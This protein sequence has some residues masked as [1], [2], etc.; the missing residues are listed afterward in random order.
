VAQEVP[1]TYARKSPFLP[2]RIVST[3]ARIEGPDPRTKVGGV[4]YS[5]GYEALCFRAP[6]SACVDRALRS[7]CVRYPQ[8]TH[9]RQVAFLMGR[10]PRKPE[11]HCARMKRGIDSEAGRYYYGRRL[12]IVEPVFDNIQHTKTLNRF[13]LRGKRKVDAQWKLFCLV[14]N[15]EKLQRYRRAE[16][17]E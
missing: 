15:I 1:I 12:G 14:H 16:R 10:A 7:Q 3:S 17:N 9:V 6:I 5:V 4:Q 2:M 11:T 13:T 8:R